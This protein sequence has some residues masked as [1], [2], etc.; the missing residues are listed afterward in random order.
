VLEAG[1]EARPLTRLLFGRPEAVAALRVGASSNLTMRS[2]RQGRLH[3]LVGQR[4]SARAGY[5]FLRLAG[6]FLPEKQNSCHRALFG[7]HGI[8]CLTSWRSEFLV[9]L[10]W[11]K[12][13]AG[14]ELDHP[15]KEQAQGDADGGPY[16]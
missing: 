1:R 12:P 5:T 6:I 7:N 14:P 15:G 8:A 9:G 16:D 11:R 10:I 4:R 13:F 3:F 2:L